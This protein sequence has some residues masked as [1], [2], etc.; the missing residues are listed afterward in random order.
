M[1]WII[2]HAYALSKDR[3]EP[4]GLRNPQ[5]SLQVSAMDPGRN[6]GEEPSGVSKARYFPSILRQ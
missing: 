5:S 1:E 2:N 3:K 6:K 4:G